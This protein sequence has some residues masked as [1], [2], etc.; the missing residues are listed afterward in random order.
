MIVVIFEVVPAPDRRDNYLALAAVLKP[1]LAQINGFLSVER[2]QS[3]TEP[4]M[5][6]SLSYFRDEEAVSRWRNFS[7]HR[8]TQRCGRQSVFMDYR[9][10]VAQ[11][12][13]DY[14]MFERDE[15]PQDSR[16][17]HGA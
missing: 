17:S 7:D 15:A 10:H 8:S 14:G 12:V 2:F 16:A 11:V 1:Q 13:R 3:L 5:I 4:D 9:L 6:L